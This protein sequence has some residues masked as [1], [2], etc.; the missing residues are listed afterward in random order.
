MHLLLILFSLFLIAASNDPFT[1]FTIFVITTNDTLAYWT[2]AITVVLVPS[3]VT[4]VVLS[5]IKRGM[6]TII[7]AIVIT[8]VII[9]VIIIA[10][11]LPIMVISLVMINAIDVFDGNV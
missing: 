7:T 11:S 9:I 5:F 6:L 8:W 4:L 1:K 10:V 2:L 3:S